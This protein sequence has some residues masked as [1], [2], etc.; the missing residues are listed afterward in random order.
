MSI[1]VFRPT[2][3]REEL[4]SVADSFNTGWIG[5]GPKVNEFEQAWAKHIGVHPDNVVSVNSCT[6]G[7]FTALELFTKYQE[8]DE[9]RLNLEKKYGKNP[10]KKP[11]KPFQGWV[12]IPTIHFIGAAQA[13][14]NMGAE[15]KFCDVDP[16]TLNVRLED[17]ERKYAKS[18]IG[19]IV[20]HYGGVPCEIAKIAEFCKQK[21]MWLIEDCACAPA[22]TYNGQ[23]VGTFGDIG[24]WSFDAMKIISTGDGG[25]MYIRDKGL[26]D[27]ARKQ[28]Y[29]G[30]ST[31]SG[32][33]SDKDKWWE[34]EVEIE[35]AR[36][37]VMNDIAAGIG[38][39]QLKKLEGF[40]ARRCY[41]VNFY[42]GLL[43]Q[44]YP[45]CPI[46][47]SISGD[48]FYFYWIQTPQRDELAKF[49]KGQEIYTTFRYYPLHWAF[50][51]GDSLPNAEKA[52]RETLLL[53]LHCG[54][55]DKDVE[56][57]CEKVREFYK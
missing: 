48:S 41:L 33:S 50:R 57:V 24:V 7:L 42:N 54:L 2:L 43:G 29:L 31:V 45:H 28:L 5:K 23:A 18:T 35:G 37:S 20:N 4:A 22:S 47:R 21:G 32:L 34:F 25:M 1:N 11:Y 44:D 49:L 12:T 55:T 26:A 56:F 52:A 27:E 14:L 8:K 39:E 38:I 16:R 30:T 15:P 36:R 6:E 3:G 13:I 51:T 9:F 46:H 40:I 17:I 10:I 53:P 19:V